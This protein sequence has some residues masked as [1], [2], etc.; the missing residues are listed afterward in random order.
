MA[1]IDSHIK[2]DGVDGESAHKDHKGEIP[3]LQW[4]WGVTNASSP[5]GGGSGRGKAAPQDFTFMHT[6]DKASP[7]LAKSCASGKHF[8]TVVLTCRKS[9][10]GQKDHLKIT[11]KEVFITSVMPSATQGGDILEAVS[12]SYKNFEMGYKV[13]DDKGGTGGEVKM[14]WDTATTETS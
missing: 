1:T 2:F 5:I 13:Q 7:V 10:E 14:S 6:L 11:M 3:V 4:T 9:G 12:C 8:A